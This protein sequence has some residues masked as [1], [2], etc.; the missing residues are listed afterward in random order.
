MESKEVSITP[1]EAAEILALEAE[2]KKRIMDDLAR[3]IEDEFQV[4]AQARVRKE[5]E[6]RRCV[7]LYNSPL[8]TSSYVSPDRPFEEDDKRRRPVPNIVRTKCDIAVANGIS[9]Q[10]AAG[11]KN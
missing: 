8:T 7:Q 4:R 2:N 11:N 1:E 3:K 5:A 10:F 9:M 6:W